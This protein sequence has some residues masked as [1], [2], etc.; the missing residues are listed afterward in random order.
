MKLY[1]K[2][3]FVVSVHIAFTVKFNFLFKLT[4]LAHEPVKLSKAAPYS[5]FGDGFF[6]LDRGVLVTLFTVLLYFIEHREGL[7][8]HIILFPP[9][10]ISGLWKKKIACFFIMYIHYKTVF[11]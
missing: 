1:F 3:Y 4:Q 8:E 11:I 2:I 6:G 9:I 10:E 5:I 7:G